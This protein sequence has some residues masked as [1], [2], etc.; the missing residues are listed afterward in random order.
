MDIEGYEWE[1]L[2]DILDD[3]DMVNK[4][5]RIQIEMHG[6]YVDV[7]TGFHGKLY[8]IV[9]HS[10]GRVNLDPIVYLIMLLERNGL[11]L[12][13]KV[14]KFMFLNPLDIDHQVIGD[15]YQMPGVSGTS[16]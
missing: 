15:K 8:P 4:V 16:F 1:V 3:D 5:G 12:F 9:L 14:R 2:F 7:I 13:H 11:F 6:E 10:S